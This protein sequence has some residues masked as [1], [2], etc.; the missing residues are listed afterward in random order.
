[1]A[2]NYLNAVYPL[3]LPFGQKSVLVALANRADKQTGKCFPS[4]RCLCDDTGFS[5]SSVITHIKQLVADNLLV[6]SSRFRPDK[7]QRTNLYTLLV[8]PVKS[9]VKKT[10]KTVMKAVTMGQ[11]FNGSGPVPKPAGIQLDY[12]NDQWFEIRAMICNRAMELYPHANPVMVM[13]AV[14]DYLDYW[15]LQARSNRKLKLCVNKLRAGF[16]RWERAL[17]SGSV[18]TFS[19][20]KGVI[21]L[22]DDDMEVLP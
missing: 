6:K 8:E 15:T 17:G 4:L 16:F 11:S 1:M 7:S 18:L 12:D 13:D 10:A 9:A 2:N 5:R 19:G 14:E 22:M 20:G 3:K 21:Q